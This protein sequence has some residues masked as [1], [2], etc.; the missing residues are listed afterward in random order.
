MVSTT[1]GWRPK[2]LITSSST[3]RPL[4]PG[5]DEVGDH[6]VDALLRDALEHARRVDLDLGLHAAH[7]EARRHPL[8]L[9]GIGIDHQHVR[10]ADER[11]DAGLAA[12][13]LL[14]E[15]REQARLGVGARTAEDVLEVVVDRVLAQAQPSGDGGTVLQPVTSRN[16]TSCSRAVSR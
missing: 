3:P 8:A 12:E 7:A 2:R 1:T 9:G 5:S 10:P 4:A 15:Q 13:R 16:S 11:L 6:H 14:D